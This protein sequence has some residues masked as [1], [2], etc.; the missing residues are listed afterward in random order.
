MNICYIIGTVSEIKMSEKW[1]RAF[2]RAFLAFKF[3]GVVFSSYLCIVNRWSSE[4]HQV[5]LNGR[6]A[7]EKDEVNRKT[8]GKRRT[9]VDRRTTQKLNLKK[10]I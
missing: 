8:G 2:L 7:T 6:V 5:H 10:G 4:S 9:D 3:A 1:Q